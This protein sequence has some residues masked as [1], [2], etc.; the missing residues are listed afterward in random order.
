M[1]SSSQAQGVI[2]KHMFPSLWVLMHLNHFAFVLLSSAT[3]IEEILLICWNSVNIETPLITALN[4]ANRAKVSWDPSDPN[5]N[6]CF[7]V[8][9]K[10]YIGRVFDH[11]EG[12]KYL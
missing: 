3:Q 5:H 12:M 11:L 7:W 4:F 2:S 8:S 10:E 1:T 9:P 6:L